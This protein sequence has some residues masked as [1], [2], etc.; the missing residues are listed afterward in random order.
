M[1]NKQGLTACLLLFLL[2]PGLSFPARAAENRALLIGI[3]QYSELDGLSYSDADARAFSLLL[4]NFGDYKGPDVRLVLNQQATKGRIVEEFNR[5]ILDSQKTPLDTFLLMFAGHGVPGLING[6]NTSAFLAPSDASISG[7]NF[8]STGREV[9]NET[10]IN[11]AWLARQLSA[12]NAKSVLVILD[13]CYSGTK[14]FGQLFLDNAG[15][16]VH[17]YGTPGAR[18][19]WVL[20]KKERKSRG[21]Q[22][23]GAAAP[24][25]TV[26]VAYLASSREDQESA[27]Y[28]ELRHGALSYCILK[29][30]NDSRRGLYQDEKKEVTVADLYSNISALF[31]QVRV[32]AQPLD[33][34][35]QPFLLSIP[36]ASAAQ[37]LKFVSLPGLKPRTT[38]NSATGLL[39]LETDP[40]GLEI[41]VDGVKRDEKTNIQLALPV[42]KHQVE[43]YLPAGNYKETFL[44]DI[45][46]GQT[47]TQTFTL[48][49]RLEVESFW[50]KDGRKTAGPPLDVWIDGAAAGKAPLSRDDLLA[51]THQLEVRFQDQKKS[52]QIEIRP[53]SPLAVH[54]SVVKGAEAGP[55]KDRGVG[56]VV[57]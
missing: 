53:D 7:N 36:D 51:G 14:D 6:Q 29:Y 44:V 9:D 15:Y 23:G 34:V 27:E 56:S 31:H 57:F 39:D 45:Q 25:G 49:G 26:Q 11:K 32:G 28:P 38:G 4:L 41:T 24:G 55:Q 52:R 22:A 43:L 2:S 30:I 17:S 20:L 5:V 33:K 10:F 12:V 40:E 50:L 19:V 8:F 16:S 37:G 13:S 18:G 1:R 35:H 48:K 46:A 47:V 3:S 42:G 21:L 54:Y